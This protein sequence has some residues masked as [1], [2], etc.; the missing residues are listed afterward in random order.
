MAKRPYTHI[1]RINELPEKAGRICIYTRADDGPVRVEIWGDPEGLRYF[2]AVLNWLAD[3][4]QAKNS[5]PAGTREHLHL[6]PGEQIDVQSCFVGV[7]RAD[8]KGTG[9]L[10]KFMKQ[11]KR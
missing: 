10:P 3:F 4:D 6:M 1:N 5:D 11:E 9:E 8:A 2:A 7:S